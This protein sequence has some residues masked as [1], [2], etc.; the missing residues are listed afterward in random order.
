MKS[1]NY[2]KLLVDNP[3]VIL[4]SKEFMLFYIFEMELKNIEKPIPIF[5]LSESMADNDDI[6]WRVMSKLLSED[7]VNEIKSIL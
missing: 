7:K 5:R 6:F 2:D 3:E 1:D 4:I